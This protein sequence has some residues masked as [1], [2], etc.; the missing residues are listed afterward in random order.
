MT[1]NEFISTM[2]NWL[3]YFL[4]KSIDTHRSNTSKNN[5]DKKISGDGQ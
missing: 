2:S 1:R 5:Q 4:G 3:R